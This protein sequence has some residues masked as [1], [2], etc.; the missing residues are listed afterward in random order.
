MKI[1]N[2]RVSHLSNFEVLAHIN[3]TK[4]RYA[5]EHLRT[6]SGAAMKAENL[7]TVLKEVKDYLL[8]TPAGTQSP[9]V[10][11]QFFAEMAARW[12]HPRLEK[13]ELLQILNERPAGIAELDCIIE[14]MDTRFSEEEQAEMVEVVRRVL[15]V[16]RAEGGEAPAVNGGAS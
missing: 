5:A 10:V 7:E 1:L 2:P 6:S 14:E 9:A 15:P 11:Q 16:P 8:P 3:E 12:P 4:A 13:V